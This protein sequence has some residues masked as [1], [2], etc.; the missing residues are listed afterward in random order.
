[1]F[2]D[3]G[4]VLVML[5]FTGGGGGSRA[6]WILPVHPTARHRLRA[7]GTATIHGALTAGAMVA[8][9][10]DGHP[11]KTVAPLFAADTEDVLELVNETDLFT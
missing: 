5:L 11:V 6:E 8:V 7:A 1:M 4:G 2:L 9:T 10:V 3:P